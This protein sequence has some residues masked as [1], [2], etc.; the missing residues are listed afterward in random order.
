MNANPTDAA[1]ALTAEDRLGIADALYRLGAGIDEA[2]D[3]LLASAFTADAI[4]D[5]G[6]AAR[7][8]GVDFPPLAGRDAT[9]STLV[10]T[11]GKLD[12]T[13]A[14]S[15]PRVTMEDGRVVLRALVEAAHFP[16]GDRSRRCVMHNRYAADMRRE[17]GAWRIARLDV[18][19]A[20]FDGDPQV[21][22]GR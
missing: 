5:F 3:T 17:D 14:V 15:N 19:C 16:P 11:V 9:A 18:Q 6:P 13:H 12:T 20:W 2:S 1:A 7:A 21:L 10:A 22:L 8:M 4:V